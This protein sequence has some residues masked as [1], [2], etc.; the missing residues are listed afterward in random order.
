MLHP[1]TKKL[2]APVAVTTL[3]IILY[4]AYMIFAIKAGFP[5]WVQVLVTVVALILT[6]AM[7]YVL[8]T[9]YKEIMSGEEDD[10]DKY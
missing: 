7:L 4:I 8:Y 10:L 3:M 5:T 6:G 9:R 2:I 1:Y